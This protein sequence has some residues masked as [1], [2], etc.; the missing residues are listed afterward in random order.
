[1]T[2]QGKRKK[3]L[4]QQRQPG[5]GAGK[6]GGKR[7]ILGWGNDEN[8]KRGRNWR[9]KKSKK[10]GWEELAKRKIKKVWKFETVKKGSSTVKK[11]G[12]KTGER[13]KRGGGSEGTEN[14]VP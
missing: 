5:G 4:D 14:G 13:P 6:T 1:L 8:K 9:P 11:T 10:S 2:I 12:K 7:L 3:F